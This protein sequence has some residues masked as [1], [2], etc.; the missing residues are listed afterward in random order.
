MRDQKGQATAEYVGAIALL[1][2]AVLSL[3]IAA[4]DLGSSIATSVQR[5]FC[6]LPAAGC[7]GGASASSHT[8][9][10]ERLAH[11]STAS[12]EAPDLF[13]L[14][15]SRRA[16]YLAALSPEQQAYLVQ[17]D[18]ELIG[19]LDGA[20]P[21]MRYAANR[22]LMEGVVAQLEGRL[23]EI[24]RMDSPFA[25]VLREQAQKRLDLYRSWVD[26][27]RR[28]LLF[29]PTGD[30]GVAE[31]IGDIT[32][33]DHVAILV[34]G[35]SSDMSNFDAFAGQA[36]NLQ[37]TTEEMSGPNTAVVAWLGYDPPDKLYDPGAATAGDAKRG[38]EA[39]PGFVSGLRPTDRP[40]L[41]V[42][43]HS[44]GSVTAGLAARNNLD[45]DDLVFI[46]SP[47]V[48]A[49]NR[50][51]LGDGFTVWAAQTP[52]DPIDHVPGISIGGVGHGED[53]TGRDFGS[54]VFDTGAAKGHS[55]YYDRYSESLYNLARIVTGRY[56]EVSRCEEVGC[57]GY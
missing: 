9:S 26:S 38:A 25:D 10:P 30:G 44:Y 13:S 31:V 7:A 12:V 48:R 46:G 15:P 19:S 45:T 18:P 54:N 40:H 29:D 49:G 2:A 17:S 55:G 47:G 39:L 16:E 4:P 34:P 42:V 21:T 20:P 36:R 1:A 3:G 43:G 33:A 57:D 32:N 51:E 23:A 22:L 14:S 41:T 24:D 6:R 50:A 27:D 28:F 37:L 8:V 52:D 35:V 5:A 11:G 56:E 53:P